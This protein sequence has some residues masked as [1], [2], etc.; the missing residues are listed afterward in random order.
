GTEGA[1]EM[2]LASQRVEP[3]ALGTSHEFRHP[4]LE[5]ALRHVL[6]R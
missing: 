1:E 2:A 4:T 5:A 3:V 6:G